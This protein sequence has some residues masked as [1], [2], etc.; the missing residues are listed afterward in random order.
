MRDRGAEEVAFKY[1]FEKS[2][3]FGTL[4]KSAKNALLL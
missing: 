2:S 1:G 3:Y 4:K